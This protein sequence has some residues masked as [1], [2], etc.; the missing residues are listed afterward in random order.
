MNRVG[1]ARLPDQ[2]TV[3]CASASHRCTTV[4]L[5]TTAPRGGNRLEAEA[6][7]S[8][9]VLGDGGVFA[10]HELGTDVIPRSVTSQA[11]LDGRFRTRRYAHTM[12]T[13]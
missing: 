10:P 9:R 6:T 2:T 13:W 7:D 4:S 11:L 5:P 12:G 1:S 3:K 8:H